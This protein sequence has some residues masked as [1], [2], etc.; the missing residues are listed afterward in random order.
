MNAL[1]KKLYEL[2]PSSERIQVQENIW[3]NP[4]PQLH[5]VFRLAYN[6]WRKLDIEYRYDRWFECYTLW[7]EKADNKNNWNV[8]LYNPTLPLLSQENSTKGSIIKLFEN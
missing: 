1:D 3:T 8:I 7:I 4:A 2:F 5:D 6:Q